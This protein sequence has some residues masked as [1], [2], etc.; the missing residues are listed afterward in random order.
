MKNNQHRFNTTTQHIDSQAINVLVI[1][2]YEITKNPKSKNK[3]L[4]VSELD[5]YFCFNISGKCSEIKPI[6]CRLINN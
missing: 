4:T 3:Y 1:N 2:P 5:T 6:W